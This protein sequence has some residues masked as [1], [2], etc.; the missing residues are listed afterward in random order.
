MRL[1][2]AT[3]WDLQAWHEDWFHHLDND[4]ND[5]EHEEDDNER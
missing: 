4:N 5:D 3:D 1:G 2:D